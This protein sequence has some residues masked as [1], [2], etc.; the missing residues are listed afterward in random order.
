MQWIFA[1]LF[2]LELYGMIKS[3]DFCDI[4]SHLQKSRTFQMRFLFG[5]QKI[6]VALHLVMVHLTPFAVIVTANT[7]L[8]L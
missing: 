2:H 4:P 1:W 7:A 8:H 5:K 6:I 3:L